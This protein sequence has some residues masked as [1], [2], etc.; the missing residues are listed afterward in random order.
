[1]LE[2]FA[3]R[4]S[5][6][7]HPSRDLS[8]VTRQPVLI[9]GFCDECLESSAQVGDA[10]HRDHNLP[11]SRAEQTL[12]QKLSRLLPVTPAGEANAVIVPQTPWGSNR[13]FP[14]ILLC[15]YRIAVEYDSPGFRRDAHSSD[16]NDP[17]KDAA[18]RA[19]GWEVIR[20]RTGGL[21][22]L[23]PYDVAASG[24]TQLAVDAVHQMVVRIL[25]D[26]D[27]PASAERHGN[28]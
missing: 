18:L 24:P 28:P 12:R 20:V 7:G 6:C 22:L 25:E 27:E 1:M 19:A 16:G 13:V 17:G 26:R 11:T 8:L 10:I 23:G 5:R 14:D 4:Y 21:P 9:E 15:P 3:A 2:N